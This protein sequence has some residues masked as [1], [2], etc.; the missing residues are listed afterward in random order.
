MTEPMRKEL[1]EAPT[2]AQRSADVRG[3]TTD[4][5][6]P[7]AAQSGSSTAVLPR[8]LPQDPPGRFSSLLAE[9]SAGRAD[10]EH[11]A[12]RA[13]V[14]D[15]NLDQ[16]VEAVAGDREERELIARLLY[17]Q[18]CDLSAL[19]YRHEVFR[20][21]ED[22][23]LLEAVT[24]FSGQMRQV[25]AHLE[26]LA[27]MQSGHQR[28]GWFLDAATIY[29]HAVRSLAADLASRPI[30]SRGLLAFR[31]YLGGYVDSVAFLR[32][33]SDT[34]AR[35]GDLAQI[36]YQV[37]IRGPRVE[38]SRY[39]GE[40]DYSAEIQ[41]TFERFQQGAVKDYRVQYRGWPGMNHVGAQILDLVAR[42]FSEEFSALGDYYRG[43]AGFVD[44][45]IRQFDRELQFYL[46]Y[47]D[48]VAPLRSAGLGFCYPELTVGSKEIFA[49]DTFD[50]ALAAK[51]TGSGKA[52][53]TNEF[54]L[55]DPERV[56]VVSGP[57]QGGKTTFAR[58]FGQL[59]HLAGTG[60]PVPGIAARLYLCDQIFTHFE[61]EEDIADLTGKLEND[62]LRIQ[63]ALLA[64]T[65]RSIVV[66]NEIFT[67]TT[68]SDARFLG[69]KVLA[70][71]IELDLLCVYVTFID[72]LASL[73]PTVVS[74]ASTIVPENPAERT[75]KVVRKPADGLAY[76]LAIADRHGV[77]YGQ[78]KGRLSS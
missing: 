47:L 34:A 68:V 6:A 54:H 43:H 32:L 21:L 24:R 72:E 46:A 77:T 76:A 28:E 41:K 22:S 74:M 66:M 4:D 59:H 33:A 67:S 26:Q 2:A 42:L 60:C 48:Y 16:I 12:D 18:V 25:R 52:V 9:D 44:P 51:L 62:L 17:Q 58:T 8:S 36:T 78:L 27:K 13:L 73:G 3:A 31:V 56:I 69:E 55:N 23:G 71:V 57:N 37:R 1:A 75:Y 30:R 35:K 65:P 50:L 5:A 11:S 70:K 53:I 64:A 20:D 63:Q 10:C 19:Q 49:T 61:R 29:C 39:D 7:R 45:T 38:V 14:S 40:P 15:L